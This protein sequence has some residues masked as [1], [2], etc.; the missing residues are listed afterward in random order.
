[1]FPNIWIQAQG[2]PNDMSSRDEPDDGFTWEQQPRLSGSKGKESAL[3]RFGYGF[4]WNV[5]TSGKKVELSNV[6]TMWRRVH[7]GAKSK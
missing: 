3:I 4:G 6:C 5:P 2:L 7:K 1:M